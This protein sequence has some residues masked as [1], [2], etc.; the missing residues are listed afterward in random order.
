LIS[1]AILNIAAPYTGREEIASA[2]QSTVHEWLQPLRPSEKRPFSEAHIAQNIQAQRMKEKGQDGETRD[3]ESD[4]TLT[5]NNFSNFQQQLLMDSD[6]IEYIP[7]SPLTKAA[8]GKFLVKMSEIMTDNDTEA[9][10]EPDLIGASN[11]ALF[12]IK[13]G[14]YSEDTKSEDTIELLHRQIKGESLQALVSLASDLSDYPVD[15]SLLSDSTTLHTQSL[16]ANPAAPKYPTPEVIDEPDITR[17]TYTGA[18]CPPVDILVRTSGV[19]RL[20]DFLLWQCHQNTDVVFLPC[21]W[22]QFG[23]RHLLPIVLEW[24]WRAKKEVYWKESRLEWVGKVE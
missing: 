4:N 13:H 17:H 20:S 5:P 14:F 10:S 19:E 11:I 12:S 9:I 8:Y 15:T 7:T 22:P 23:L 1:R 6:M 18:H 2:I 24:Q 3:H 21:L 16:P